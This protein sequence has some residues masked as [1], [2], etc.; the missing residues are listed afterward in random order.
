LPLEKILTLRCLGF[1]FDTSLAAALY[2]AHNKDEDD[3]AV[4]WVESFDKL[5]EY[6]VL[7]GHAHPLLLKA[8]GISVC[9]LGAWARDQRMY[10]KRDKLSQERVAFLRGID[11]CFDGKMADLLRSEFETRKRKSSSAEF[12]RA[13]PG[14]VSLRVPAAAVDGIAPLRNASARADVVS[15][16]SAVVPDASSGAAGAGTGA[17]AA[18]RR[19]PSR[20]DGGGA[21]RVVKL[22]PPHQNRSAAALEI[23]KGRKR[24]RIVRGPSSG[25]GIEGAT[26]RGKNEG[27]NDSDVSSS[28]KPSATV[29]KVSSAAAPESDSGSRHGNTNV[30]A[31]EQSGR[32]AIVASIISS[33][34]ANEE[35]M[36]DASA[37]TPLISAMEDE[38]AQ[39]VARGQDQDDSA[40][41]GVAEQGEQEVLPLVWRKNEDGDW[42][43]EE[44]ENEE[45]E[46]DPHRAQ[47]SRSRT[48]V[49]QQQ[50]AD[51]HKEIRTYEP[52]Y[53]CDI[54][55]QIFDTLHV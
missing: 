31:D 44:M 20:A 19:A 23:S 34:C 54:C 48:P 18:A 47:R 2:V 25:R 11:F 4:S 41:I 8:D 10:F 16:S 5:R 36:M 37:A 30:H 15:A 22:I 45:L 9:P 6:C 51:A 24:R 55:T 38:D 50:Q 53:M 46:E 49:Q 39:E 14:P 52:V 35:G 32:A 27:E 12:R 42:D 21:A 3:D 17:G 1:C 26:T 28:R 29:R 33:M 7:H 43:I 13:A 40:S